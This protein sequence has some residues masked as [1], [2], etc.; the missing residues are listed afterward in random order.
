LVAWRETVA[1]EKRAAF[2]DE[3]YWGRPVPGFGDPNAR[4]LL[5]G[6]APA[7]HGGNRTGR[8][9]T[10]DRSGDFL[11]A[12]LYRT[13][14]ANRPESV[15]A[16]DGLELVD[17]YVAAAVRCAPPA[18]KPTPAERDTCL[19]YLVRELELL[20]HV[21][22]IVALGAFG[23]EAA[24]TVLGRAGFSGIDR[25]VRRPR[26][27]HGAE[28]ACGTVTIVGA[29]HPSQQNTFTGRL[30]PDMLDA[31]FVRARHLINASTSP[32]A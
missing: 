6:L 10:G 25:P 12:S 9:F 2:R 5:V 24:W 15:R 22:V 32:T 17:A 16:G 28:V 18:N 7:A 13:G 29:F 20:R 27:A 3:E 11:F 8:V 14:F 31:V 19:P 30:T 4:L 23:Y 21:R 1:R 26:F